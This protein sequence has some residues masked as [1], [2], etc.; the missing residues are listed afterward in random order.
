MRVSL[1]VVFASVSIPCA[2][3]APAIYR[4]IVDLPRMPFTWT[5]IGMRRNCLS[6]ADVCQIQNKMTD[7]TAPLATI[8]RPQSCKKSGSML[9]AGLSLS[10][11][12]EIAGAFCPASRFCRC[13]YSVGCLRRCRKRRTVGPEGQVACKRSGPSLSDRFAAF[14]GCIGFGF[15][16]ACRLVQ[17]VPICVVGRLR[18]KR[19]MGP[20]RVVECHSVFDD[21]LGLEAVADFFEIDRLLLQ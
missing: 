16:A 14:P 15:H 12:L 9:L 19:G 10:V 11:H 5:L 2:R 6:C 21:I 7:A 8:S 20:P 3:K 1:P 4:T 17:A 13:L 18:I